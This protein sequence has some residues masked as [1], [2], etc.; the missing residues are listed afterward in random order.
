MTSLFKP[1]EAAALLRAAIEG[2][3]PDERGRFGPFGGDSC[4]T[5]PDSVIGWVS[6]GWAQKPRS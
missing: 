3:L 4:I 6:W 1:G 2:R 5:W